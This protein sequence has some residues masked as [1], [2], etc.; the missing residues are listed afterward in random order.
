MA[1]LSKLHSRVQRNLFWKIS[2]FW[3][4]KYFWSYFG[5]WANNFQVRGRQSSA[6][7]RRNKFTCLKE[8]FRD[9]FLFESSWLFYR[10]RIL[11]NKI[12]KNS[13]F[14]AKQFGSVVKTAF[15]CPEGCVEEY[16]V[17]RETVFLSY[18]EFR[19]INF[20]SYGKICLQV[21]QNFILCV[22]RELLGR[23][24]YEKK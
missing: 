12:E 6:G 19:S 23:V 11:N 8:F 21:C 15:L 16:I 5:I 24:F 2:S 10:F 18:F 9:F 17:F 22:Q 14:W 7:L 20:W 1:R 4:K 13:N 3:K